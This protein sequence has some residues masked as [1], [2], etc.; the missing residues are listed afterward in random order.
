[1]NMLAVKDIIIKLFY[2]PDVLW[3]IISFVFYIDML[4]AISQKRKFVLF[5][6]LRIKENK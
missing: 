1:M 6:I 5:L 4:V 3:N 2:V